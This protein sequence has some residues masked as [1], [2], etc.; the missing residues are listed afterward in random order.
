M[1][2]KFKDREPQELVLDLTGPQGN[3]YVLMGCAEKLAK[4]LE[5]DPAP[6][7][8][9]MKEGDYENLVSV[10]DSEFGDYVTLLR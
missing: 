1:V 9:K 5:R 10:F 4:Q 8:A 2:V 3:A 6:I 7:L